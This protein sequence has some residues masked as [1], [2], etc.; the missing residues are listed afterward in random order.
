MFNLPA[1]FKLLLCKNP[2][3]YIF[4]QLFNEVVLTSVGVVSRVNIGHVFQ[5]MSCLNR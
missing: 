4:S 1:F 5:F 2:V 3:A